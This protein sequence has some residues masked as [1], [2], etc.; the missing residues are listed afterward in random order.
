MGVEAASKVLRLDVM[1]QEIRNVLLRGME[2]SLVSELSH[3]NIIRTFQIYRVCPQNRGSRELSDVK[4]M[5][6]DD[7]TPGTTASNTR[8]ESG[9]A[10]Q[11]WIV[12]EFCRG[13]DLSEAIHEKVSNTIM[14]KNSE[15]AHKTLCLLRD[16]LE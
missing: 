5:P 4:S 15:W 7:Q 2:A 12:Q 6:G 14:I 8:E 3:P 16:L 10:E 1:S 11:L 9:I 13:G